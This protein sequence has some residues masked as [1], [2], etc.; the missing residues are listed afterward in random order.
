MKE[1]YLGLDIGTNSC[2]YALT[3]DSYNLIRLSGKDVWGVRLF[4]EA[5]TAAERRASRSARR[6]LTRKKLQNKWLNDIFKDEIEK[7]DPAFYSRL[8]SS[9]LFLEDK[10]INSKELT[11]KDS[12]FNDEVKR[13]YKDKDYYSEYK[14]VYHLRKKLLNE[15]ADDVRLLY[16]AIHSILTHRG[17]FLYD[18]NFD[19]NASI[20]EIYIK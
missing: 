16:L 8:K 19:G 18:A 4:D 14:T 2:G 15:P 9:N 10:K 7:V 11:S 13:I 6:R 17:H 5:K 20:S 12:L 1:I 3:D